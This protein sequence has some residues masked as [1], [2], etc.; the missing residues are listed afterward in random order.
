MRFLTDIDFY[1]DIDRIQEALESLRSIGYVRDP[2]YTYDY[3][4]LHHHYTPMINPKWQTFIEPHIAIF[5]HDRS[6][7][8]PDQN[9]FFAMSYDED[10]YSFNPTDRFLH[11]YLHLDFDH[12]RYWKRELD[13]KQ[14]YEIAL[15]VAN[16]SDQ[17]R[18]SSIQTFVKKHHI[19]APFNDQMNF[20]DTLFNISIPIAKPNLRSK[21]FALSMRSK[22]KYKT[23]PDKARKE[24][25]IYQKSKLIYKKMFS[26]SQQK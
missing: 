6:A 5:Y 16:Y 2:K 26:R 23:D 24:E 8:M 21:L 12:R 15:L 22:F 18:W 9:R 13:L 10:I 4:S 17:I 25:K 7:L 11:A 20:I 14:L 1:V 19:A 3:D